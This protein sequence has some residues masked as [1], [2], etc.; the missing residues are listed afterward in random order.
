M[1]APVVHKN[2]MQLQTCSTEN[3]ILEADLGNAVLQRTLDKLKVMETDDGFYV[4]V[5]VRWAGDK[6][7]YLTTRR[8]RHMPKVFKDLKRLND[9]LREFY[10][11][12][13]FELFR[14]MTLPPPSNVGNNDSEQSSK[15]I[16]IKSKTKKAK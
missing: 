8:D 12:D 6:D 10:P 1:S 14:G 7:W 2:R 11:T 15:P 13:S 3:S 16:D 9:H 5:Q 4:V